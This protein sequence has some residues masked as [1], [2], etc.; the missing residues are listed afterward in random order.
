MMLLGEGSV[1]MKWQ[2][3]SGTEPDPQHLQDAVSGTPRSTVSSSS[4]PFLP[5]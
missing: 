4:P 1:V 3:S 2:W 5:P